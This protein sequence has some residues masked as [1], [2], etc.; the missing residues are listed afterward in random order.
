[1]E[2]LIVESPIPTVS[3]PVPTAC[4]NDSPKPSSEA[5]LISKRVANQKETPSL[6]NIL[7]LTNR[8]K[9][10]LRVTTSS[11][12]TIGVKADNLKRSLM[13]CKTQAGWKLY[14]KSSFNSKS[15]KSG[16][17]LIVLK[18]PDPLGQNEFSRIRR[19]KEELLSEIRPG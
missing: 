19:M 18:G 1:M 12:E 16:L 15:R 10:I 11:D 6:D 5:R 4:L 2:S 9:D 8:F 13:L 7:L 14:K 17:W 3:S